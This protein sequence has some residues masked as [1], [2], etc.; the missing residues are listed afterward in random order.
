MYALYIH[1][2]SPSHPPLPFDPIE[3]L[4][5]PKKQREHGCEHVWSPPQLCS[6]APT[7]SQTGVLFQQIPQTV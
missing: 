2:F 4:N 1:P 6:S 3:S 5:R 7:C